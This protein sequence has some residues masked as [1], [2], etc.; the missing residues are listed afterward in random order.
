MSFINTL[1][2]GGQAL[3]KLIERQEA[4]GSV[5]RRVVA[6]E[7]GHNGEWRGLE[8]ELGGESI[9]VS[10][11]WMLDG[12]AAP[13]PSK[14]AE[15][16]IVFNSR[17][18]VCRLLELADAPASQVNSMVSL[19]LELELPFPVEETTW[20][21]K[22]VENGRATVSQGL[23]IAAVTADVAEA[24]DALRAKGIRPGA[25]EFAPAGLAELALASGGGLEDTVAVADLGVSGVTLAILHAGA[26]RYARHMETG[27]DGHDGMAEWVPRVVSELKQSMCDYLL[28]T[29][30]GP[31]SRLIASGQ[32]LRIE[33][34][35]DELGE[36]LGMPV[37]RAPWPDMVQVAGE[38]SSTD[39][40]LADYPACLGVLL[41]A[42]RRLRNE[43][44]VAPPLRTEVQRFR[45]EKLD[46]R[47]KR[48]GL[49][50]AN[51]V[52]LVAFVGALMAGQALRL[53]A[54]E[55][56]IEGSR[57]LLS[58]LDRLQEEVSL[59]QYEGK[60][61]RPMLDALLALSEIF[62][63]E[64]QIETLSIDAKGKVSIA[65][66]TK[67]VETVSDEAVAAMEASP[68]FA[69]PQFLGATKKK[70]TYSFSMT[71]NLRMGGG[72]T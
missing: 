40:L 26:L 54:A 11:G 28:R 62:P 47:G 4:R 58:Q 49:L 20:V 2:G 48:A 44:T 10:R 66:Q 25:V 69:S 23:L 37:D 36:A 50:A 32:V 22:P 3:M 52:A 61:Q 24:E 56:V 71:C 31:P 21:C 18:A 1:A 39:D 6:L 8:A 64:I 16:T 33:G 9:A 59:L 72:G 35:L 7:R 13:I 67:S 34:L 55:R 38:V 29:D 41:A 57:P 14:Q 15:A 60:R 68:L 17:R 27:I 43:S 5:H 45:L 63:S 19:R 42:H 53:R 51:I 70:D 30:A 46:L 12:E 65:G